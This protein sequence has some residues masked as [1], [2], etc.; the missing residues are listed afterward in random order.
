MSTV[1]ALVAGPVPFRIG[2][3]SMTTVTNK[4]CAPR[5]PPH[6]LVHADH[7]HAVE[8]GRIVDEH[9]LAFG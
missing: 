5:V 3:K 7:L 1:G 8:A 9:A 4:S 2:V 6:E